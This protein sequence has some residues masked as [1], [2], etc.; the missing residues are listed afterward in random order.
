MINIGT[1]GYNKMMKLK[2]LR[3]LIMENTPIARSFST[4]TKQ[5]DNPDTLFLRGN[6]QTE[7]GHLFYTKPR[8]YQIQAGQLTQ[9]YC[10]LTATHPKLSKFSEQLK[11][12]SQDKP[13]F[14]SVLDASQDDLG[15]RANFGRG[16]PSHLPTAYDEFLKKVSNFQV[17]RHNKEALESLYLMGQVDIMDLLKECNELDP[18]KAEERGRMIECVDE[19]YQRAAKIVEC[20]M[21]EGNVGK[22]GHLYYINGDHNNMASVVTGVYRARGVKPL[23]INL[24]FHSDARLSIDGPHSGTWLSDGYARNEIQHTYIIG[25][26]LLSN[27]DACIDNLERFGVT[28]RSYTWDEIQMNGGSRLALPS[29]TNEVILDIERRFGKVYPVI[30]T[31]DGDTV[32]GLPCSAQNEVL[33]YP[34]EDVYS[35][36]ATFTRELNVVGFTIQELKP[37]L[38]TSKNSAVGEFL[39]NNLFLYAQTL[40]KKAKL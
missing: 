31:I 38:D 4:F 1:Q 34:P 24:D 10:P 5:I 2:P 7:S 9:L 18:T 14:I 12:A 23:V 20:C 33:G 37:G 25:L 19:H 39:A 32:C 6:L 21:I 3:N 16:N 35:M 8:S 15:A 26:S 17:N 30:F 40:L 28:Y 36:V 27:S 29:I 22:G 11:Q 13:L